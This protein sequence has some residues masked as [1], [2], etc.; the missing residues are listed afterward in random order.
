MKCVNCK[1]TIPET[2]K[3]CPYCKFDIVNNILENMN[4][5]FYNCFIVK[6]VIYEMCKL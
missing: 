6:R 5:I 4:I 1:Q 2:S 3:V